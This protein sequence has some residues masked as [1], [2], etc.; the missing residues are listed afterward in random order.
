MFGQLR[1]DKGLEDLLAA[2]ARRA[3][4]AP[5]HRRPGH[6]ALAAASAQLQGPELTDA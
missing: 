6:G 3:R 1:T 4:A 2:L 5:A